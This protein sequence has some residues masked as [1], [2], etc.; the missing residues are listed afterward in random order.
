MQ[1]ITNKYI[2]KKRVCRTPTSRPSRLLQNLSLSPWL[3]QTRG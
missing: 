2:K 1:E 3:L